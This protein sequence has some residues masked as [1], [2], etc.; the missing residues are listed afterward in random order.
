[1]SSSST[2]LSEPLKRLR[3]RGCVTVLEHAERKD[4]AAARQTGIEA[5][6]ST[7][8]AFLDNDDLRRLNKQERLSSFLNALPDCHA[9]RAGYWM[10][11]PDGV[12]DGLF[13]QVPELISTSLEELEA[14]PAEARPVHNLDYLDIQ[15]RSLEL[16]L[17]RNRAPIGTSVVREPR[18]RLTRA[19]MP[20]GLRLL[21]GRRVLR[22]P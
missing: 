14:A 7:W 4:R 16:L 3:S 15:G 8:T 21:V 20:H 11:S 6:T 19:P 13:G 2:A 9:V 12:R 1:M 10:F 18:A 5:A 22:P 17:E